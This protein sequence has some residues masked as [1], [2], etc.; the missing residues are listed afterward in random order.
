ML[1]Y[2]KNAKKAV[3]FNEKHPIKIIRLW[4]FN[5]QE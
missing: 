2:D 1:K 4:I 5:E 3:I